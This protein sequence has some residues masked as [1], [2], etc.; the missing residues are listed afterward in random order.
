MKMFLHTRPV[1]MLSMQF[2]RAVMEVRLT[3]NITNQRLAI[4]A[5]LSPAHFS[6][7][8]HG[9]RPVDRRD[10]RILKIG[11]R[12]GLRA[13]ECFDADTEEIAS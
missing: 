13:D 1:M 4:D 2:K 8:L 12:L 3:R 6:G 7:M 5:N 11:R 9:V 10:K